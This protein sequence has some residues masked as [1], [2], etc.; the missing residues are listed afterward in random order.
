MCFDIEFREL[1]QDL[2][3]SNNHILIKSLID[4]LQDKVNYLPLRWYFIENKGNIVFNKEFF[5]NSIEKVYSKSVLFITDMNKE[6]NGGKDFFKFDGKYIEQEKWENYIQ[7]L[8]DDFW[9]N[10]DSNEKD[11]F[12]K[13]SNFEVFDN[14]EP[15]N[16][17][18][19]L[20]LL[21]NPEYKFFNQKEW[22]KYY[23]N[24]MKHFF[25]V[26]KLNNKISNSTKK[27]YVQLHLENKDMTTSIY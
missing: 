27:R 21:N 14:K 25:S 9:A 15:K 26:Y 2:S 18:E 19:K 4:L 11:I 8:K 10:I 7:T 22:T 3:I 1:I 23:D 12:N 20:I 13:L 24:L 6:Y 5:D 17:I 16:D